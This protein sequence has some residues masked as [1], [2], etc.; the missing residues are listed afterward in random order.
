ML[1]AAAP[2]G[3][4]AVGGL[5]AML[6]A[7]LF[8]GSALAFVCEE[9]TGRGW[10]SGLLFALL[11][12]S[13][14]EGVMFGLLASAVRGVR[15]WREGK[16]AQRHDWLRLALWLTPVVVHLVWRLS[17]YGYPLP[18]T[19]Y[20]KSMGLHPRALI[21]GAYYLYTSALAFG[22]ILPLLV[23]GFV[24][25]L[26]QPSPRFVYLLLSVLGYAAFIL[27][28]G[29][30]WMPAQ[31][32]LVHVLPAVVV[33]TYRGL[34]WIAQQADI[35]WQRVLLGSL[36][37][38]QVAFLLLGAVETRALQR[39]PQPSPNAETGMSYIRE[40]L[41]SGD[42]IA[43][44]DAGGISYALPLDIRVLDMFGLTDAHI[45]HLKPQFPSGLFGR[46]DGFGKWDVDYVL[47]R[48]PHFVQAHVLGVD[49]QGNYSSN[50]SN[51]LL[52]NDPR[53]K[54]RYRH[55]GDSHGFVG[56]FERIP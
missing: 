53:F 4:W 7:C 1:A 28:G 35:R 17:Y 20:A 22:G 13:R 52:L 10:L 30:D 2:F 51:R 15:L 21:E 9:E 16:R 40:R 32:F 34:V 48:S 44:T 45:A 47:A 50:T 38:T 42:V 14:P 39:L 56:L 27:I 23:A 36:T 55:L 49:E 54:A 5:E 6:F 3:V 12:L 43:V 24:I 19:V 41:K 29:G 46:G 18:N 25:A 33:L 31:R 11:A 26:V 37:G 8:A